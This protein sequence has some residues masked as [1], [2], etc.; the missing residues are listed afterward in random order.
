MWYDN[1]SIY[2]Y[3]RSSRLPPAPKLDVREHIRGVVTEFH[4]NLGAMA[5]GRAYR[6]LERLGEIPAELSDFEVLAEWGRIPVEEATKAGAAWPTELTPEEIMNYG[7][8]EE[9][10]V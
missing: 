7:R 6:L 10:R 8:T 3:Q 1:D 9:G 5:S 4:N 2:P